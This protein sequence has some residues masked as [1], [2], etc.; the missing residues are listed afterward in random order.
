MRE[1]PWL[2]TPPEIAE[3]PQLAALAMLQAAVDVTTW[4]LY[5]QHP[6]ITD[7]EPRYGRLAKLA[8]SLIDTAQHL[9]SLIVAYR[10]RVILEHDVSSKTPF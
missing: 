3:D 9:R 1:V 8:S 10:Q 4:A 5:A 7:D 2:P 6:D